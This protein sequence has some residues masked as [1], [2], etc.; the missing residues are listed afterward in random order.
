MN[1]N[2]ILIAA[3]SFFSFYA[4]SQSSQISDGGGVLMLIDLEDDEAEQ[5]ERGSYSGNTHVLGDSITS[6]LDKVEY[7]YV[8]YKE[9]KGAYGGKEKNYEK[10][11]I[12]SSLSKVIRHYD[13]M[14]R[15]DK[16]EEAKAR[17]ELFE[18]L[19]NG[20]ALKNYQTQ[21]FEE[22][23]KSTRNKA[24]LARLFQNVTFQN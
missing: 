8:Y 14:L 18:I 23:L 9:T 22:Q 4:F 3:F 24:E 15:K 10:P 5:F 7:T 19:N 21:V 12:Y 11:I 6:L 13:K 17:Q 20:I 16:I 1:K 2:I